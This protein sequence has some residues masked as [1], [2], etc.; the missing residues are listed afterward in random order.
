M[1]RMRPR[2][3]MIPAIALVAVALWEII[4][5]H[6]QAHAVPGD[7]AWARA[8]AV[9]RAGH[10]PGDL[11]VFAPDWADPIGRLH[12]GDLI[13]LDMA[14]R[15]DGARYP[16]IWELSIRGATAKETR[17]LV[18]V[19]E[20]EESSVVVRRY[21]QPAA[22]VLADVR[23]LIT[24]AK[25][26]GGAARVELSEVGF[27]PHRCI[28]LGPGGGKPVR[29]TFPQL[30]LGSQLVGYVGI[31]DVFTRRDDRRPAKLAI[32][33]AGAVAGSATAGVDDGW[34][35]FAISTKPG[36]ADV[37]FVV[38]ANERQ[39]CFAAEARQ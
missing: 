17:G 38:G 15:M 9:V 34:V 3:A 12:L 25:V 32:E 20:H 6:R 24:G 35:R 13:S 29:I 2:L 7:D 30:A 8:A 18:A 11:I 19:E 26:S 28:V 31:P 39:V 36:A 33:L 10:R 23:E 16:R 14:G 27:E 21:D 1:T 37:T 4:A 22:L 5:T